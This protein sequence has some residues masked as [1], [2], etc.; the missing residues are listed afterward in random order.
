MFS[1]YFSP[2]IRFRNIA[3]T[4]AP[5]VSFTTDIA[6]LIYNYMLIFKN[7]NYAHQALHIFLT[8]P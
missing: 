6:A 5:N 4:I 1:T 7:V 8:F 3:P 2:Q